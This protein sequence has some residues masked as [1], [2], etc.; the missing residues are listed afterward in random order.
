MK[1]LDS[2]LFIQILLVI[3]R[4]L[5]FILSVSKIASV[6]SAEWYL[7]ALGLMPLFAI[8]DVFFQS[9]SRYS[10]LT[11]VFSRGINGVYY[12]LAIAIFYILANAIINLSPEV[13]VESAVYS[14]IL[15][16]LF[17]AYLNKFEA[18]N[19]S[20]SSILRISLIELTGYVLC[21]T[22]AYI[23]SSYVASICATLIFPMSRIVSVL[24]YRDT[25]PKMIVVTKFVCSRIEF[26]GSAVFAQVFASLAAS[27]PSIV[28]LAVPGAGEGRIGESLIIFKILFMFSALTSTMI[29]LL[30]ARVF[31][32][33]LTFDLK[34]ICSLVQLIERI[35]F[36]VVVIFLLLIL[37]LFFIVNISENIWAIWF[38]VVI[39]Y[40]TLLS[41]LAI[42]RGKPSVSACAQACIC[43]GAYSLAFVINRD[44]NIFCLL[45]IIFSTGSV[46]LVGRSRVSDFL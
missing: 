45:L 4:P 8:A 10:F 25:N 5:V 39:S 37:Y 33:V 29:N 34:S 19:S 44:V 21:I 35:M 43:F 1:F 36:Y 12:L 22:F 13:N 26:V 41:S 32:G 14:L 46:F 38:G 40:L 23:G 31:Y 6:A 42:M 28:L 20:S 30:S 2:V 7:I 3:I 18:S 9:Y 15:V 27:A 17:S 16:Y 24:F 11:G